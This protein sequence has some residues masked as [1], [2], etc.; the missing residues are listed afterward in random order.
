MFPI[1]CTGSCPHHGKK[2]CTTKDD[3]ALW[4]YNSY[5]SM[6]PGLSEILITRKNLNQNRK[7]SNTSWY[8]TQEDSIDEEKTRGRKNRWAVHCNKG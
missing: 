1:M 4:L 8:V 5:Y 7:Y 6:L 3:Q 2:C